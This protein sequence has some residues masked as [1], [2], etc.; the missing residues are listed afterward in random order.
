MKL[1]KD[2]IYSVRIENVI[3]ST[4]VAVEHVAF[5][6]REVAQYSLF[7]AVN[8]TQVDGHEY[9][10]MAIQKGAVAIVCEV[11]PEELIEGVTYIQVLDSSNALGI[12]AANF[13]DNPSEKIKLVGV[14]G[15]NGKTTSVT[16]MYELFQ[17]FGERVGLISTVQNKI[18]NE[19]YKATHTTPNAIELNALL[20]KMVEKKCTYCFMEVSSH[21]VDQKRVAGVCFSGG[22]FTNISRDHLDYHKT[23]DNYIAA[24]KAFFDALPSDAFALTN[25]DHEYGE[26]MMSETKAKV[27]SYGLNAVADFK[28]KILENRLD[29]SLLVI[30][31]KEVYTKLIGKFNAYNALVAYAVGVLLGKEELEVLTMLSSL[32]PPE[33]RF[34]HVISETGVIAIVDYAHTPD[35]LENVLNTIKNIRTGNELVITVVGCGGD[36]D[37]GKRPLMA[38]VACRLSDQVVF[39]SDNPRS[40]NPE[41]IIQE[42]EAGVPAKDYRKTLSITHRREAIKT[43]C[44]I[45]R[46]DD[47]ILIAGKGHE[48]YQ[49]IKDEVLD[50]D[51]KEIVIE[52]LKKLNK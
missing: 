18:H 41:T 35:A 5:D 47:I 45:A 43:A 3:G 34:Q 26:V 19:V 44:S 24:K 29:G 2:I 36:R 52:I 12:V 21:A 16:L 6:S 33:G 10:A 40:E 42:M 14:T 37:K 28:A 50:F 27:H 25:E 20:A 39:T 13:Y 9:I 49:I 11:V 17:L 8:G 38:E 7:V 48:K 30:D 22:V 46:K 15:T 32:T 4:N 31:G 51:D 23:F 1:L